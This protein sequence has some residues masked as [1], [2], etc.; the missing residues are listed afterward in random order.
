MTA[1]PHTSRFGASPGS[2]AA[3]R[4]TSGPHLDTGA[5]VAPFLRPCRRFASEPGIQLSWACTIH[6]EQVFRVLGAPIAATARSAGYESTIKALRYGLEARH[7]LSP[8]TRKTIAKAIPIIGDELLAALDGEAAPRLEASGPWAILL[9][10]FEA[11]RTP[12]D[13]WLLRPIEFLAEVERSAQ[14]ARQLFKTG[15]ADEATAQILEPLGRDP[16]DEWRAL[17]SPDS[18]PV[19]PA[20]SASLTALAI[21]DIAQQSSSSAFKD[22]VV[23]ALLAPDMAPLGRWLQWVRR[24]YRVSNN[25]QL[26]G[27]LLKGG[28]RVEGARKGAI[29]HDA[30]RKWASGAQVM[31][32]RS[33]AALLSK[34]PDDDIARRLHAC[35]GVARLLMFFVDALVAYSERTASRAQVQADLLARYEQAHRAVLE[36]L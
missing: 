34:L 11:W 5:H 24:C 8:T 23:R 20:L 35:H 36:Q 10:S 7:T 16:V 30:L 3:R 14:T 27:H 1:V 18:L 6:P 29:T 2:P 25:A 31:R 4:G 9:L 22:S 13:D 12:P 15:H 19:A 33:V 28:V 21:G 17:L 32:W 26:A